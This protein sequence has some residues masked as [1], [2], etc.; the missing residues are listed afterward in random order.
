MVAAS[1]TRV[2]PWHAA[3]VSHSASTSR[4]TPR[5]V[6]DYLGFV[7]LLGALADAAE[8]A[9]EFSMLIG[10]ADDATAHAAF[11]ATSVKWVCIAVGLA[12]LVAGIAGAI[13]LRRPKK[14]A[15]SPA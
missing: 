12:L 7:P 15:S 2:K 11:L 8:N 4:P 9:L 6:I 13:K 3:A 1:S 10:G 5:R 14:D